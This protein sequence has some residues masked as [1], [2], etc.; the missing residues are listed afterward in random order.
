MEMSKLNN[1]LEVVMQVTAYVSVVRNDCVTLGNVQLF[2]EALSDY[3][4]DMVLLIPDE[5]DEQAAVFDQDGEYVCTAYK[6]TAS[7]GLIQSVRAAWKAKESTEKQSKGIM[8]EEMTVW[9]RQPHKICDEGVSRVVN[10]GCVKFD[11]KVYHHSMLEEFEGMT[12]QVFPKHKEGFKPVC[13]GGII[14]RFRGVYVCHINSSEMT[15]MNF[16]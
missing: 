9:K 7:D 8:R 6:K 4:D 14:V 10:R 11:N 13:N 12:V 5:F 1:N 2:A 15:P 3:D 16:S